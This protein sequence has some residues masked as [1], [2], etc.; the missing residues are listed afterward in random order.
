MINQKKSGAE[1]AGGCI[2]DAGGVLIEAWALML[3]FGAVH[4]LLH[5]VPAV[6]YWT[7]ALLV[8]GL[9]LTTSRVRRLFKRD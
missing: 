1:L 3:V 5:E 8:V 2:G 7:A 4:G 9:N 6:G